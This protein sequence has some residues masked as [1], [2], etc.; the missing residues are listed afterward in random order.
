MST[1][2]DRR[3]MATREHEVRAVQKGPGALRRMNFGRND[4]KYI[5]RHPEYYRRIK[6]AIRDLDEGRGLPMDLDQM[7][8]ELGL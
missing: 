4:T 2:R 3:K 7:R 6:E 1:P 5:M 8:A